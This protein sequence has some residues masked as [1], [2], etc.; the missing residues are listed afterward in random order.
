MDKKYF[1]LSLIL[2]FVLGILIAFI[3]FIDNPDGSKKSPELS[4]TETIS[5]LTSQKTKEEEMIEKSFFKEKEVVNILLV[6]KDIGRER[7][8]KGQTG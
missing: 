3:V 4:I 7:R 8:S 2:F 5:N 1:Y 6:G